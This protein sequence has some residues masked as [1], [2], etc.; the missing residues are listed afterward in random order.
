MFQHLPF[1]RDIMQKLLLFL[2]L[3]LLSSGRPPNGKEGVILDRMEYIYNLK[4]IIDKDAWKGF[5]D[6]EFD[7]PLVYYTDSF[8]Y[9]ANPTERFIA[10][11]KPGLVFD[12]KKLKI[13]KT[14][15]LDSI[16]FHMETTVT[17]GDT[18]SM[19]NH[20]SPFMNCSS[21]EITQNNVPGVNATEQWATMVI[22]EYF[23][24][25][26]FKHP[27]FLDYFKKNVALSADTLKKVYKSQKWFKESVDQENETLLA[28]L[29]ATDGNQIKRLVNS[30]FRLRE[31]RRL[32]TRQQ[33][34]FNIEPIE[35]TFEN[36]EGTARYVEY[37]LY[38]HFAQKK[39]S[40]KLVKSDSSYHSYQYFRNYHIEKDQWLYLSDKTPY[41]YA[42]GFNMV[43][44][45][46]KLEINYQTVLFTRGDASLEQILKGHWAK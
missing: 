36:M 15:L 17:F 35:R 27:E 38:S 33:L 29:N 20:N 43:R 18:S 25:F 46:N 4:A 10:S 14:N 42:T 9:V 11:F 6:K 39:P 28:A 32:Q 12:N 5:T 34:N 8:C 3:L 1:I 16:P 30:F 45:L 37:S 31:Q 22:H 21:L 26:Q 40:G 2:M 13:Y 19:Y 41:Y 24:G 23:H 44:L 7:L